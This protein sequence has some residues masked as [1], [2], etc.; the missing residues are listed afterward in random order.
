MH[1]VAESFQENIANKNIS[2]FEE[3]I[4]VVESMNTKYVRKIM[5]TLN[6]PDV[7]PD[8]LLTNFG[9]TIGEF[10]TAYVIRN[11][12]KRSKKIM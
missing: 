5:S 3:I 8:H 4:S 6:D 1:G 7:T 2:R 9:I 12:T 10:C 11:K